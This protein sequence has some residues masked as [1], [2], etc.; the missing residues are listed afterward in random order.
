MTQRCFVVFPSLHLILIFV[1]ELGG[2]PEV[3]FMTIKT[4][5]M[6]GS[7]D[8]SLFRWRLILV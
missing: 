1:M 4:D 3:A 5:S 8:V 7:I 6:I 2:Y